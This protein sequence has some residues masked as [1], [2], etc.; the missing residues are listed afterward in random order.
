[1][2]LTQPKALNN[3]FKRQG[4]G[5]TGRVPNTLL[6]YSTGNYDLINKERNHSPVNNETGLNWAVKFSGI[7]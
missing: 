3:K 7:L 1:M 6:F 2:H 5:G 4:A